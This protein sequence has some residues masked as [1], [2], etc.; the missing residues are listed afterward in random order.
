MALDEAEEVGRRDR[1]DDDVV[2][3]DHRSRPRRIPAGEGVELAD[4]LARPTYGKQTSRPSVDVRTIFIL[5]GAGG[6]HVVAAITLEREE[7]APPIAT[8]DAEVEL[9]LH[10]GAIAA[11]GPSDTAAR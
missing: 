2:E 1:L 5:P 11:N 6:S 7:G 8:H 10:S 3:G 9:R 4:Q